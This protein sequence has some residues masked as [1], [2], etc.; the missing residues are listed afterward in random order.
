MIKARDWENCTRDDFLNHIFWDYVD[1][2]DNYI[3]SYRLLGQL[4]FLSLY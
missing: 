4:S 1:L 2:V 3:L